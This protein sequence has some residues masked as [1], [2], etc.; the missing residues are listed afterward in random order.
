MK[1][2]KSLFVTAFILSACLSLHAQS[3]AHFA[4]E[5]KKV[6]HLND[7]SQ[8]VEIGL[9]DSDPTHCYEWSG[10]NILTDPHQP[11][12]TV[13]PPD[14]TNVYTVVRH[15]TCGP[16]TDEVVVSSVDTVSL[17]S[18]TPLRECYNDGDSV[19]LSDFDI[20]TDPP[21]YGSLVTVSPQVVYNVLW[22]DLLPE[23]PIELTFSLRY[24]GHT[25]TKKATVDVYNEGF[26]VSAGSSVHLRNIQKALENLAKLVEKGKD[27]TKVLSKN[28]ASP[29]TPGFDAALNLPSVR[30]F[31]ACCNGNAV[32]G[33]TLSGISFAPTISM[34][35][36][37]PL[38]GCSVRGL[39]GFNVHFGLAAGATV[40][41]ISYTYKGDC[42]NLTA[43]LIGAFV[44]VSGGVEFEFL[45]RDILSAQL[46]LVGKG[47]TSVNWTVGEGI[48][49]GGLTVDLSVAGSVTFLS[50]FTKSVSAPLGQ[51][52]F[53]KD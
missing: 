36:Y 17:V 43:A 40:G 5:D 11:V 46:D 37:F 42:S 30:F 47:S 6:V 21:G 44:Q 16:E 22:T 38:P 39:G 33:F 49:W 14:P 4:G 2:V 45:D 28:K 52:V 34:D 3:N 41:P 53:F 15:S 18:V 20:V 48:D 32:Q 13:N 9:P 23:K 35:C 25:S 31:R 1:P 27:I 50:L 24:G 7:N 19:H 12:I 10:P 51:H 29:C 26:T 8:Q